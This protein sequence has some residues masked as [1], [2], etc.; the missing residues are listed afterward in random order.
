M[1]LLMAITVPPYSPGISLSKR[2][3]PLWQWEIYQ[4]VLPHLTSEQPFFS[5]E[6]W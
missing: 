1:T 4:P 5:S 6:S 3:M 2:K